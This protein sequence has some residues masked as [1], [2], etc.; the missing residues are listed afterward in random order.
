MP[1]GVSTPRE[2]QQ[3]LRPETLAEFLSRIRLEWRVTQVQL[4]D[5]LARVDPSWDT[6]ASVSYISKVET[7]AVR[8]EPEWLNDYLRAFEGVP[9]PR[10]RRHAGLEPRETAYAFM[11]L[12]TSARPHAA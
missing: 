1:R 6:K 11:L 4:A 9:R 12:A 7:G 8:P 5:A 2:R 3:A 10:H